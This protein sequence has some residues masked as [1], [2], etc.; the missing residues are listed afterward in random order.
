M[1][2]IQKAA[3]NRMTGTPPP[4]KP[5]KNGKGQRVEKEILNPQAKNFVSAD[6][7]GKDYLTGKI[8]GG[9]ARPGDIGFKR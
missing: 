6:G 1:N 7:L 3:Q 5:P 8:T 4:P 2:N 9:V